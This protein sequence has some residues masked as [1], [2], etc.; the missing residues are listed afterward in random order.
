MSELPQLLLPGGGTSA[1]ITD[2]MVGPASAGIA[3]QVSEDKSESP[4]ILGM[5]QLEPIEAASLTEQEDE[6][7]Y[8]PKTVIDAVGTMRA[9]H[10]A[11]ARLLAAGQKPATIARIVDTTPA[12]IATLERSPHFQALLQEYMNAFDKEAIDTLTRMKILGNLTLDELTHRVVVSPSGF[13]PS[14]LIELTKVVAD[15]TGLGPTS[16][17]VVE[18]NG[19]LSPAAIREIKAAPIIA[20]EATWETVDSAADAS[21]SIRQKSE[22][23]DGAA[24][25]WE[26]VREQD[27][28]DT[29]AEHVVQSLISDLGG[30]FR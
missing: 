21:A 9:R 23:V 14:E 3:I 7:R 25:G 20:Q 27:R 1:R 19:A 8:K 28:Q 4:E 17:Q 13:K 30:I 11:I 22:A 12:S 16:K 24:A 10:H 29:E 6:R 18:H 5:R 15:R 2:V 26:G